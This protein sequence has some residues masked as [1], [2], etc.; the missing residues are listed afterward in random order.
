MLQSLKPAFIINLGV[1]ALRCYTLSM[2][3]QGLIFDEMHYIILRK[4]CKYSCN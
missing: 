4:L 2:Q 3:A 1:E